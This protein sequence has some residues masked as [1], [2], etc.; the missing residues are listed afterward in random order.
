MVP[1]TQETETGESQLEVSPGKTSRPY[2]KNN[3]KTKGLDY[4][5]CGSA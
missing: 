1:A 3:L 5:S 4:G 2:L